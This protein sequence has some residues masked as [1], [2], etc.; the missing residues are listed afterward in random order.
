MLMTEESLAEL[1]TNLQTQVQLTER[2]FKPNF[3][4]NGSPEPWAEDFW[5]FIRIGNSGQTKSPIFK[6]AMPC[7]RYMYCN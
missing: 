6:T 3:L 4:I 1:N 2:S 5:G 7:M